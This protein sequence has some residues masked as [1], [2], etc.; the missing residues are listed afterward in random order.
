[1]PSSSAASKPSR[2]TMTKVAPNGLLRD[3]LAPCRLVVVVQEHVGAGLQRPHANAD[4]FARRHDPL[5]P[6][7]LA[8]DLR[9]LRVLVGDHEQ[10]GLARLDLHFLG[11]DLLVLVGDRNLRSEDRRGGKWW[12]AGG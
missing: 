10:E 5:E 12:R 8:L 1:M 2:R 11:R 6:E 7:V 9:R 3:D 4:G